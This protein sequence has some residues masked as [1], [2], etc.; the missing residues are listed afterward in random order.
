M[1]K[2]APIEEVE[3]DI[4]AEDEEEEA[5]EEAEEKEEGEIKTEDVVI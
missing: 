3:V 2:D 1:R 5:D 4:T